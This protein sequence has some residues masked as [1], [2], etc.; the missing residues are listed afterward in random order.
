MSRPNY[1]NHSAEDYFS[2]HALELTFGLLDRN[3]TGLANAIKNAHTHLRCAQPETHT[4]D[5]V[6]LNSDIYQA[7]GAHTIGKIVSQLTELG[8]HALKTQSLPHEKLII[9]RRLI[10]DWV[11]LT[12]WILKHTSNEK[13]LYN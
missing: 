5:D 7:L 8:E 2:R 13:T 9:L 3:N 11:S 12:E 4:S 1:E 6:Y 10:A